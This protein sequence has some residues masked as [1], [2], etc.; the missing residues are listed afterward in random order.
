LG[1]KRTA[2]DIIEEILNDRIFYRDEGGITLTGG[3]PT[4]QPQLAEALLRL[5]KLNGLDT[6]IETSGHTRYHI[7]ERILPYLDLILFDIKCMDAAK[8]KQYAGVDNT[9][10]LT[11]LEKLVANHAPM[12]IRV[13]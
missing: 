11:N 2:G 10:I 9:L 4:Y 5:A 13:P 8:H 12:Q 6:T 3:E 1:T 7:F